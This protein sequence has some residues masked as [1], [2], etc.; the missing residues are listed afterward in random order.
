MYNSPYSRA[1][2]LTLACA[3]LIFGG[4]LN[5]LYAD[6]DECY[7]NPKCT[8]S[9]KRARNRGHRP[10]NTGSQHRRLVAKNVPGVPKKRGA[11]ISIP[12]QPATSLV[13][14]NEPPFVPSTQLSMPATV[15]SP[16][17][18]PDPNP[19]PLAANFGDTAVSTPSNS[20]EAALERGYYLMANRKHKEATK[21]FEAIL[22]VSP[23]ESRAYD[24][25]GDV[26][27]AKGRHSK[28]IEAYR[29]ALELAP[30]DT[31]LSKKLQEAID[32]KN[33]RHKVNRDR[34]IGI[35]LQILAGAVM[36]A[37][38]SHHNQQ[39]GSRL[40]PNLPPR[41]PPLIPKKQ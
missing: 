15:L 2:T 35:F 31:T 27:M 5:V 36:G 3:L 16:P 20:V 23:L 39:F 32:I 11:T 34:R 10:A 18:R 40:T 37:T 41:L 12:P 14:S 22:N 13:V 26:H 1:C 4:S 38:Q 25:I 33:E 17:W 19:V 24:G 21:Q 9:T 30:G 28:A 6:N 7:K 8:G 29:K